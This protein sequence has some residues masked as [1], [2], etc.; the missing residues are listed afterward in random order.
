[1][2][3]TRRLVAASSQFLALAATALTTTI[4]FA[5]PGATNPTQSP[6]NGGW[7]VG[8]AIAYLTRRRAFGGWLCYFYL[9][10]VGVILVLAITLAQTIPN[11][12]PSAWQDGTNFIPYVI[13]AVPVIILEFTVIAAAI[14]LTFA[15]NP[16]TLQLMRWSLI[17]LITAGGL[18]LCMD[19]AYFNVQGNLVADAFTIIFASIWLA[20]FMTSVRVRLVF[21][22]HAWKYPIVRPS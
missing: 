4:A 7:I 5:E 16:K 1:M 21:I 3:Q 8:F 12:H 17:G 13:G 18:A 22:E 11:L 15:R 14:Y 9:Q 2:D 6:V 10:I 20:Y 19:L